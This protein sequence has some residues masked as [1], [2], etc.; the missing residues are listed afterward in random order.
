MIHQ[1]PLYQ[2]GIWKAA[3]TGALPEQRA[4]ELY[5]LGIWKAAKT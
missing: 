1:D 3:K 2:L 4:V 5:Q